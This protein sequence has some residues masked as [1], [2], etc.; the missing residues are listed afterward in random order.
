MKST[1]DSCILKKQLGSEGSEG[2]P[3][4]GGEKEIYLTDHSDKENM[5]EM[6][7]QKMGS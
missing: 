6:S 3:I 7:N 2:E 4:I 5:Q 1:I